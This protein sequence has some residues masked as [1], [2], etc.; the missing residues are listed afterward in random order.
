MERTYSPA[1]LLDSDLENER[2][3]LE[4]FV[5]TS[6]AAEPLLA[7]AVTV[8]SEQRVESVLQSIVQ[9]LSSQPGVALVRIWL[10]PSA[11]L[12]SVCR[13]ESGRPD[14][15]CL[16]QALELPSIHQGKIGVSSRGTLL[17]CRSVSERLD[18]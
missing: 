17:E 11:D 14:S 13:P 10:L 16:M 2:M 18:K 3:P 8:T 15:L 4:G 9:G 6:L 7:L 1:I 12:P 5:G